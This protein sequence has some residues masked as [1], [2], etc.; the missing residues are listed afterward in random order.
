[1][2]RGTTKDDG[3]AAVG[4]AAVEE[5][6]R[7]M[8]RTN[9]HGMGD[10][11]DSLVKS[12]RVVRYDAK[13]NRP[14]DDTGNRNRGEGLPLLVLSFEVSRELCNGYGTLHGGAQATAVDV[15]TSV[16]LWHSEGGNPRESVTSDLRVS[17]V[18]P[19]PIGSTVVC[20]CGVEKDGGGLRFASCD[21]YR[22]ASGKAGADP[23]RVL[24][25]KGLHTKYVLKERT[26]GF[27]GGQ[28]TRSR[29]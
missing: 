18:A 17:C 22:L 27:R 1:M 26:K 4:D 25:C 20:V 3:A 24:V 7:E 19:A 13:G 12:L 2:T 16:L 28:R 29:L 14:S 8:I 5:A 10:F 21:L 23:A 15:F 6:V 9:R 11:S